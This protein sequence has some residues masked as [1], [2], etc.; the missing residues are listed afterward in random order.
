MVVPG[1]HKD[2][3][4]GRTGLVFKCLFNF[5]GCTQY[6]AVKYISKEQNLATST[7]KYALKKLRE[8]G[9]ISYNGKI[10][11]TQFGE[12]LKNEIK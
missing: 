10:T 7:I 4:R 12:V 6:K 1:E 5:N 8:A 3:L 9:V 11:F 2:F